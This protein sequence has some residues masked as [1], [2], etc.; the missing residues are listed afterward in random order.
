MTI[1]EVTPHH[2]F[3]DVP[4]AVGAKIDGVYL[5]SRRAWRIPLNLGALRDL[6][7]L[8]Y[9]VLEL[10]KRLS[11]EYKKT[12]DSKKYTDI[13]EIDEYGLREYQSQDVSFLY[14]MMYAGVFNEQRTGKTP[15]MCRVIDKIDRKTAVI[16]PASLVLN[17]RDEIEEW[18][19]M[20]AVVAMGTKK[21]R[22]AAYKEFY[23][24]GGVLIVGKE[25]ARNDVGMLQSLKIHTL[26]VDEAHFLRNRSSK[27]S[28]AIVNIGRVVQRRYALT[29][30]PATSSPADVFGILHFLDPER[31][32]SYWQF[33]ERY[34]N[35]SK[36]YAGS[37]NIGKFKSAARKREYEEILNIVSVQRKRKDVMKW[38]PTKQYQT[39]KLKLE[40]IQKRAY[41]E[42]LNTFEVEAIDLDASTVL[43]QMTRLRQIT[44]VPATL[45]L[46]EMGVKFNFIL[47]WLEDNPNEQL[48]VFTNFSS[49]LNDIARAMT[50][51]KYT[52][53]MLTGEYSKAQRAT[54]VK[55]FQEGRVQV[56]LC[57]IEAA[58]TGL[59]LD[60]AGTV[61][62]LDRHHNPTNNE[63]AEDRIVATQQDRNL[64][65]LIIDLV[66]EDTIDEK[67]LQLVKEKKSITAVANNYRNVREWLK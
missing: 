51:K 25:T 24:N 36:G 60:A 10:G 22:E 45:G 7:K 21:K 13:F 8:G 1:K 47:Q 42:M 15:T 16:C 48:L 41:D 56:L 62:F 17:W 12:L 37:R 43:A 59:T 14:R 34:F 38:L 4:N 18:T 31:W 66:C 64:N 65:A 19:A 39:V 57:N 32:S 27:Q 3:V 20:S 9:D 26:V 55:W 5:K 30:T 11:E 40:G 54:N 53:G 50:A 29:G 28:T 2:I 63:Q 58:G 52:V 44:S 23:D 33:A 35:I 67:I 6:H 49:G 46:D 61:I